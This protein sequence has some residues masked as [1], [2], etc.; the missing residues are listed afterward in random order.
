[1]CSSIF[2]NPGSVQLYHSIIIVLAAFIG[3]NVNNNITTASLKSVSMAMSHTVF[4]VLV[5][6]S[7]CCIEEPAA[8][9]TIL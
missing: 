2:H 1:M 8:Y 5:G 7:I 9:F 4:N 6:C 3:I